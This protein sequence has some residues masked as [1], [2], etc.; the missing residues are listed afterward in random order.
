MALFGPT[1]PQIYKAL[2]PLANQAGFFSI[3]YTAASEVVLLSR[4]GRGKLLGIGF[5]ITSSGTTVD[6]WY[7]RL[8]IYVDGVMRFDEGMFYIDQEL[9]GWEV[10]SRVTAISTIYHA[11]T[12]NPRGAVQVVRSCS[13]SFAKVDTVGGFLNLEFD[14]DQTLSIRAY[15]ATVAGVVSGEVLYATRA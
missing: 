7:T 12:V 14:Y 13:D 4:S 1:L 8:R 6:A 9:N 2:N 5:F 11:A 3:G 10:G 15:N